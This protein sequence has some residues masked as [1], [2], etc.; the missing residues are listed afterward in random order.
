M[1]EKLA[2]TFNGVTL[3][4]I[5]HKNQIW[6]STKELSI[7]LGYAR[8]DAINKIYERNKD[9]FTDGMVTMLPARQNDVIGESIGLQPMQ[10]LFSLRGCHLI[11]M[12]AKTVIA[13]QFR[14]WVLDILD[15]EV[16][17]PKTNAM[18]ESLRLFDIQEKR[19]AHLPMM[20]GLVFARKAVG[21]ETTEK[22]FFNE[23]LFC[24]R[25]LNGKWEALN[26]S[27][28]DVYDLRL[29]KAIRSHNVVLM[30]YN[31]K[32]SERQ[33]ALDQYVIAYRA[34]KPRL[35]LVISK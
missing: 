18:D 34:K 31:L 28:L 5:S 9:E 8:P 21:K 14:V 19:D 11:A 15:K 3:S 12:F 33:D 22:H 29:L 4:P 2:L 23:N 32:Q 6:L 25:A 20:E 7:A 27:D 1:I 26:E 10:R 30:Q 17:T 24:N 35:K 13:K 16:G